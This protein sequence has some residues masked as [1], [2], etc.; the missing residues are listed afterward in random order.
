M[1]SP[2]R[3][4][5]WITGVVQGVGFRPFVWQLAQRANLTGFT[6]NASSGVTVE[7]QGPQASVDRFL[8][9]L[10]TKLPPILPR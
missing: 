10:T 3:V 2:I 5:L 6:R 8:D 9:E 4:R 7:L 1:T